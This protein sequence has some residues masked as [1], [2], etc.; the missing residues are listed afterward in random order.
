MHQPSRSLTLIPLWTRFWM[1]RGCRAES[2]P[3]S[4]SCHATHTAMRHAPH[5][6]L[7][8]PHRDAPVYEGLDGSGLQGCAGIPMPQ[9]PILALP[10]GGHNAAA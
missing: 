10:P 3:R 1:A 8:K 4:P 5:T 2:A 7:H 6:F 9:L